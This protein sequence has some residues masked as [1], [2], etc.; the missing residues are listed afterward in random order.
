[1]QASETYIR[2]SSDFL[3]KVRALGPLP[4]SAILV[5]ADV[6]GLYPNIPHAE[7]LETLREALDIRLDRSV[8]TDFL[9]EMAEFVLTNNIFGFKRD[10]YHQ[11][12]GTAIGTKF[13]P[14]YA[15]IFMDKL[16]KAMLPS[17]Q[18]TGN[19]SLM[20]FSKYGYMEKR[21]FEILLLRLTHF[22]Q[23]L[24]SHLKWLGKRIIQCILMIWMK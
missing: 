23:Q 20:T 7:G 21:N 4:E 8:S 17:Q 5:T 13:A 14:P 9:I 3:C 11:L 24:S 15:C 18:L 22:T 12:N 16:E 2:D 10:M 1:M 19:V 6:V